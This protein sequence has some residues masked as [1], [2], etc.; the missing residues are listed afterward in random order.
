MNKLPGWAAPIVGPFVAG[1]IT[2][3]TLRNDPLS[4]Q[5]GIVTFTALGAGLG[6]VAGLI[7]WMKDSQ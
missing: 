5:I 4:E 1:A 6:F 7:I 2:F 3:F